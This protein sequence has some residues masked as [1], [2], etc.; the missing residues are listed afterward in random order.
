MIRFI[1]TWAQGIIVA[2]IV[3]TIIEMVLPDG[4]NKKYI[5]TIIG[6][7][8]LFT[9]TIPV[10]NKFT[11]EP[12]KLDIEKYDNLFET[13]LEV[14]NV[15]EKVTKNINNVYKINLEDEI[16]E[17]IKEKNY[18]VVKIELD[19][20]FMDSSKYGNINKLNL[21]VRKNDKQTNK[22]KKIETIKIGDD[23]IKDELEEAIST[24]ERTALK[25]YLSEE[26]GI[27]QENIIIF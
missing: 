3:G 1:S 2:V 13:S 26:Y 4:N 7:Y 23:E 24:E 11:K 25:K 10:I 9:I 20:E 6:I 21:N 15:E 16:K 17:K 22:I 27:E 8:I 19:L 14:G 12:F 5:K 18:E